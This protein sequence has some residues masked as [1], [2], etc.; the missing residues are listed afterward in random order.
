MSIL[1]RK[2]SIHHWPC[3]CWQWVNEASNCNWTSVI[4][5]A[6]RHTLLSGSQQ[7]TYCLA[8]P[9]LWLAATCNC[10]WLWLTQEYFRS[11]SIGSHQIYSLWSFNLTLEPRMFH[12]V[13][14]VMGAWIFFGE[15]NL[16][17]SDATED[18]HVLVDSDCTEECSRAPW[19]VLPPVQT[20]SVFL[21]VLWFEFHFEHLFTPKHE[22]NFM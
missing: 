22:Y 21:F 13:P 16:R 2:Q 14:S 7:S 19:S 1:E 6:S 5:C 15:A 12:H 9:S 11:H 10:K 4:V 3:Q 17:S 8:R 18:Q 20:S